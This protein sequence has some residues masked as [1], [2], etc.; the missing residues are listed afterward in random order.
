MGGVIRVS[1]RSLKCER[2]CLGG[3]GV[4]IIFFPPEFLESPPQ[5]LSFLKDVQYV[6]VVL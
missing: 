1:L 2:V 3:G 4:P 6:S 5:K